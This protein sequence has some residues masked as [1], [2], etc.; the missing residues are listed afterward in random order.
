ML[1]I[2]SRRAR[3]SQPQGS[4]FTA[5]RLVIHSR[6][7]RYSQQQGSLFTAAGLVIHSCPRRGFT[8]LSRGG[9]ATP[10]FH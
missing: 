2:H 6:R 4:L 8:T 1:V 5:A 10:D 7:V 9:E 3:Y